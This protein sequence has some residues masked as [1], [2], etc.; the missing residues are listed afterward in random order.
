MNSG[1]VADREADRKRSEWGGR[2]ARSC[3][4]PGRATGRGSRR[5]FS[6]E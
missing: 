4:G 2:Q 1:H 6:R 5:V 3:K